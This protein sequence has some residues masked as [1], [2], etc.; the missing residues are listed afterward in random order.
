MSLI[1]LHD[2]VEIPIMEINE[3]RMLDKES[4]ILEEGETFYKRVRSID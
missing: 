2:R 4:K 3:A 1:A